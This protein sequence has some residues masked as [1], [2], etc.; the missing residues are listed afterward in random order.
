MKLLTIRRF[1]RSASILA[2]LVCSAGS[3]DS[4][5][6]RA[7]FRWGSDGLLGRFHLRPQSQPD[8]ATCGQGR[9]WVLVYRHTTKNETVPLLG[10]SEDE[11]FWYVDTRF[12]KGWLC[13]QRRV[14][15]RSGVRYH[16]SCDRSHPVPRLQRVGWLCVA[17][18]VWVLNK[19]GQMSKGQQ[20]LVLEIRTD[21]GWLYYPIPRRQGLDR[22]VQYDSG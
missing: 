8:K 3:T 17:L 22:R 15:E 21:G 14:G 16:R 7:G 19:L 20:F 10:I 11:Q 5:A 1:C 4:G 2:A 13:Y 9:A 6:G 12:G 18:L